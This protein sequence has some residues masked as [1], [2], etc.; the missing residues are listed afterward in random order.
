[1]EYGK[2]GAPRRQVA[3]REREDAQ[4]QA[5]HHV[6]ARI[7]RRGSKMNRAHR[8]AR[9]QRAPDVPKAMWQLS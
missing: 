8:D 2:G 6:A 9:R 7:G 1:M 3:G 4:Q 5:S